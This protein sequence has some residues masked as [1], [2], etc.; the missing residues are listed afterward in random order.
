MKYLDVSRLKVVLAFSFL[1]WYHIDNERAHRGAHE[2]P[3]Q[4]GR[5]AS[6]MFTLNLEKSAI[7]RFDVIRAGKVLASFDTYEAA[8]EYARRWKT[9]MVRYFIKK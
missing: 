9:A 8:W 3:P 6:T 4:E 2:E 7:T 1:V 5:K